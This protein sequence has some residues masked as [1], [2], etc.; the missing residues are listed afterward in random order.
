MVETGLEVGRSHNADGEVESSRLSSRHRS[1]AACEI[2]SC[3]AAG[4]NG[5]NDTCNG[6]TCYPQGGDLRYLS[7]WNPGAKSYGMKEDDLACVGTGRAIQDQERQHDEDVL[8][9]LTNA[10][11][12]SEMLPCLA[13]SALVGQI[14]ALAPRLVGSDNWQDCG[15]IGASLTACGPLAKRRGGLNPCPVGD[16]FCLVRQEFNP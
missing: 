1:G 6:C 9:H 15:T 5:T 4:A 11:R 7:E 13:C 14:K 2:G 12:T 8:Y 10:R 16:L 3:A